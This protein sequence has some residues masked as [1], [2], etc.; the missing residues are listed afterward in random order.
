MISISF[1]K[2]NCRTPDN[3]QVF[4]KNYKDFQI[5]Y[6][7]NSDWIAVPW[8]NGNCYF[9]NKKTK[10]NLDKYPISIFKKVKS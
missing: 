1:G 6:L 3:C 5:N 2:F 10:E 4:C 9:Y 7:K 8:D